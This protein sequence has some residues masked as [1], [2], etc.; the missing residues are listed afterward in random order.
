MYKILPYTYKKAKQLNLIVKPSKKADKKI[1]IF[2]SKGNFITSVGAK[3]YLDYPNYLKLFG[4]EVAD[5]RRKLYK[6]R[7]KKDRLKKGTPG[8]YAD[9]LLW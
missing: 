3:Q 9:N 1:D 5:Q 7:H 2:D 6:I 4:K 8:Y